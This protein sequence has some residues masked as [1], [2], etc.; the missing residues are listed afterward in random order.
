MTWSTIK[1]TRRSTDGPH[2]VMPDGLTMYSPEAL[3]LQA[4]EEGT[5]R[6][7]LGYLVGVRIVPADEIP[8]WTGLLTND[9]LIQ[10][11]AP[12]ERRPWRSVPDRIYSAS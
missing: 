3:L 10:S 5:T 11:F 8:G 12:E 7:V 9:R 2:V 6:T 1:V 4:D